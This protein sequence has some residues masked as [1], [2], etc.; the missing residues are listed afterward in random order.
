MSVDSLQTWTD[1]LG[2]IQTAVL[3]IVRQ[4]RFT[5][6]DPVLPIPRL[7]QHLVTELSQFCVH[8]GPEGGTSHISRI[9]TT[10]QPWQTNTIVGYL[11]SLVNASDTHDIAVLLAAVKRQATPAEQD[12]LRMLIELWAVHTLE[13]VP[14]VGMTL[15][16]L[17]TAILD[18][19]YSVGDEELSDQ[20]EDEDEEQQYR[21]D[22]SI[23]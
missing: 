13:K 21:N 14:R 9:L 18:E 1:A 11:Q 16:E 8:T 17:V 6:L 23:L 5:P 20:E 10:R 19:H 7:A 4:D 2:R 12:S 3:A 15:D 22:E